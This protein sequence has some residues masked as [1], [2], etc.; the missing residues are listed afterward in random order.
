M[1]DNTNNSSSSSTSTTTM[2]RITMESWKEIPSL[3]ISPDTK[4][5]IVTVASYMTM[6]TMTLIAISTVMMEDV[7]Q[8]TS[9]RLLGLTKYR[10]KLDWPHMV[11]KLSEQLTYIAEWEKQKRTSWYHQQQK[12]QQQFNNKH[13]SYHNKGFNQFQQDET[14]HDIL[15]TIT[16][17][18]ND[19]VHTHTQKQQS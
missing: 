12:Q 2:K 9:Q 1:R 14:F 16:G 13:H 18:L 10:L 4:Y 6:G 11:G 3:V 8:F 5:N 19:Y 15:F 17:Y 7:L